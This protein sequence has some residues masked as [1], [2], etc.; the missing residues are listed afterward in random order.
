MYI[1]HSPSVQY[2]AHS[3]T[4]CQMLNT[5]ASYMYQKNEHVHQ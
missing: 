3:F 5:I 1:E 2:L 4:T